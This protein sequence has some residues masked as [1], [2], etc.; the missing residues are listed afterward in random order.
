MVSRGRGGIV[1]VS[2]MG[3]L[4][5]VK[6]FAA[7]GAAKAYELIFGEGLWD[8]FRDHGVDAS[9]YVVGAT[10]TPNFVHNANTMTPPDPE[11]LAHVLEG[12][13][14]SV[15]EPRTPETSPRIVRAART[16]PGCTH[17]GTTPQRLPRDT[18]AEPSHAWGGSRSCS[19]SR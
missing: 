2:S 7:Y 8:E 4:Q 14:A 6:I 1:L 16:G 15:G 3:A 11:A 12:Q 5:G 10:A 17:I 9:A 18:P 19:G 13:D